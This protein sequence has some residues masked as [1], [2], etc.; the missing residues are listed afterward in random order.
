MQ[1]LEDEAMIRERVLPQYPGWSEA[2]ISPLPGGL[3]NR[4]LL[5]E[6]EDARA[7]LQRVSP[8]F[9][10]R[11]HENIAA[12]T[13]RLAE[14][15]VTTPRLVETRAGAAYVSGPELGAGV[16]RMLTHVEGVGFDAV[17]TGRQAR[18][19]GLLIARFHRALDGLEHE[20]VGMRANVHDTPAHLRRLAEVAATGAQHRLGTEVRALAEE[21]ATAAER[22]PALPALAPR[23]CHGDLKFSNLLFADHEPPA[24]ERAVCLIDLDTVGPLSL[25]YE[26]GDAWR[27][28]CNRAGEDTPAP[29][30]DLDVMRASLE[31][32]RE[33]MGTGIDAETRRAL[34]L[35]VEWVSLELAARFAADAVLESY[36]GWDP[37][38]YA[39]RG[40]HNLVRARGQWSL[41]GAFVATRAE[42]EEMLERAL[43]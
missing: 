21:I 6:V 31:G 11:I 26:L 2:V 8:V 43:A 29:R 36:F 27:S 9:S 42:R 23:V 40:E 30:L 4:T 1:G 22:L 35:G 12:V 5:L 34:V 19:A 39:G 24:S 32:Y 18:S 14:A 37:R 17:T 13:A 20:F 33:G 7:I 16:W 38:R 25:A 15:G 28:W 10:P 41:H 3:I